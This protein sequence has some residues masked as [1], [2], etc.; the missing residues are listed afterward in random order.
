MNAFFFPF[1]FLECKVKANTR[2]LDVRIANSTIQGW[3]EAERALAG[4]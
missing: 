1:P 4:L 3:R 2:Y